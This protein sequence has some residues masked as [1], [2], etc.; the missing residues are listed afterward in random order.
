MRIEYL[1]VWRLGCFLQIGAV[2]AVGIW[3]LGAAPS[4]GAEQV[5]EA[6]MKEAKE[7]WQ[8]RCATC[9]GAGG[10]GDG[11]AGVALNPKP[12]D[13]TSEEWQK[14][15]T[16][17]YI[18]KVIVGGGQAVGKSPLMAANPDLA[19]KPEVVRGL[20]KLVRDLKGK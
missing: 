8:T 9:H 16:D 12:R 14:S 13:L 4:Y 7:I 20:T 18:E 6:A 5:S 19:G 3:V 17:D 11:P 15:V 1:K 2:L 10:K